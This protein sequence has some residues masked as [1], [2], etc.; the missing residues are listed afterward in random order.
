VT[1]PFS[2]STTAAATFLAVVRIRKA[3]HRAIAYIRMVRKRELD[4]PGLDVLRPGPDHRLLTV[5]Q[6]QEAVLIDAAEIAGMEPA[7]LKGLP[8]ASGRFRYAVIRHGPRTQISPVS[9][10]STSRPP[11]TKSATLTPGSG[12]PI[13]VGRARA[14]SG[15]RM[16][17]NARPP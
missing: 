11:S 6:K 8:L 4:L 3:D 12:V 14:S 13:E 9:P 16:V 1:E 17:K 10:R 5:H 7:S 2:T 15:I